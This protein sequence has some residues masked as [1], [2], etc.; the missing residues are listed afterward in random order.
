[1]GVA[2]LDCAASTLVEVVA[3][4]LSDLGVAVAVD[5]FTESVTDKSVANCAG[6]LVGAGGGVGFGG[7]GGSLGSSH[8]KLSTCRSCTF[9]AMTFAVCS[10]ARGLSYKATAQCLHMQV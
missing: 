3:S 2:A 6:S 9:F 1:M 5:P 8:S 4:V 10:K 7:G